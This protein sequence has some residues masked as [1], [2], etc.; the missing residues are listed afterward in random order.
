MNPDDPTLSSLLRQSRASP[1]LPPRFQDNVW[2]RIEDAQA[3]EKPATWLDMV[4][5]LLLRPKF[6]VVAATILVM[7]GALFGAREGSRLAQQDAQANYMIAVA[8]PDI[9]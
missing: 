9:H 1:P 3:P 2:R 8:P 4:A 6:A 5:V 7:A